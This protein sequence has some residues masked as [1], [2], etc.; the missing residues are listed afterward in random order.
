MATKI[1]IEDYQSGLSL[2]SGDTVY[3]LPGG[4]IEKTTL[5]AHE[6]AVLSSG[7][8]ASD[9]IINPNG[10]LHV[11]SGATVT[12]TAVGT[13]GSEKRSFHR[14]AGMILN[15]LQNTGREFFPARFF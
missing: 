6:T 5:D 15:E 13:C 11:F 8:L 1:Y 10:G 9:S 4:T 14:L 12:D 2:S 7:A 3:V